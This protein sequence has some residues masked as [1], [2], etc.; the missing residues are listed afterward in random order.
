VPFGDIVAAPNQIAMAKI[1][2]VALF[3][4]DFKVFRKVVQE[5]PKEFERMIERRREHME[6][7]TENQLVTMMFN[8]DRSDP[9]R[10]DGFPEVHKSMSCDFSRE[11]TAE[12]R[13]ECRLRM[14]DQSV[15]SL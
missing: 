10:T 12:S 13:V 11:T 9:D 4:K 14:V 1:D 8:I 6:K 15:L 7:R 5:C 2:P 3:A